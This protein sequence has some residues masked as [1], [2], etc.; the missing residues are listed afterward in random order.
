MSRDS[1]ESFDEGRCIFKSESSKDQNCTH[2]DPCQG[3][4]DLAVQKIPKRT[5]GAM[6][7]TGE[8]IGVETSKSHVP[9][10]A[11]TRKEGQLGRRMD[12]S[13]LR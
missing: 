11:K 2:Q 8:R 7:K 5:A 13:P 6:Q 10:D 9:E 4:F 1:R 12:K 3:A